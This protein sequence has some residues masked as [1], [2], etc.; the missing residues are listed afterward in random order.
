MKSSELNSYL[1]KNVVL[2]SDQGK[3]SGFLTNYVAELDDHDNLIESV[4]LNTEHGNENG[5][6]FMFNIKKIKKIELQ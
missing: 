2:T 4:F 6:G 5:Y 1:E 3:F